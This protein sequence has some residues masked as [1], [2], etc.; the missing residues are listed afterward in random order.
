MGYSPWGLK[1]SDPT[2]SLRTPV[3]SRTQIS[4][5][6]GHGATFASVFPNTVLLMPF[7]Q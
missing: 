1:E 7:T 4:P 6:R 2:E 5:P 3:T